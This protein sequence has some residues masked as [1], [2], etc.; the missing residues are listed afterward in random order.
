MT[1][2]YVPEDPP[3]SDS[4]EGRRL[5]EYIARM[6]RDIRTEF[7]TPTV[8]RAGLTLE[9]TTP[10]T[11]LLTSTPTKIAA[12][13]AQ[14]L[15]ELFAESH[16]ANATVRIDRVGLW[17]IAVKGVASIVAHTNNSTRGILVE[18]YNETKAQRYKIIDYA[19]IARYATIVDYDIALPVYLGE[20]VIGDELA[21]YASATAANVQFTSID[22]L[23]YEFVLLDNLYR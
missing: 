13:D 7:E 22:M 21:I 15:P 18:L 14:L 9:T 6:F 4:D 11:T 17:F 23:L 19:S 3:I 2:F 5:T 12:F 10:N 16:L 20:D 1:E 8:G